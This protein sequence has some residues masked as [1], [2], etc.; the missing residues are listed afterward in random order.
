MQPVFPVDGSAV[1]C[2]LRLDVPRKQRRH[3]RASLGMDTRSLGDK[4][5][6]DVE[7]FVCVRCGQESKGSS[8]DANAV[9]R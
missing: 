4:G 5:F 1:S 7:I 8:S 3:L 9:K 2:G 6:W